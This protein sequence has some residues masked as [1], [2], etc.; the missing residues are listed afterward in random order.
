MMLTFVSCTSNLWERVFDFPTYIH[1]SPK[2][3]F[4][5]RSPAKQESWD[6]T[7]LQCWDLKLTWQCCRWSFVWW[8]W[9][10]SHEL[11]V[12][13]MPCSVSIF[14]TAQASSSHRWKECQVYQFVPNTNIPR[15]SESMH[16]IILQLFPVSW[17]SDHPCKEL[18]LCTTAQS[19][20]WPAGNVFPRTFFDLPYPYD[21][22]TVF[23]REFSHPVNFLLLPQK[24][25]I[26]TFFW[27]L[28][29]NFRSACIHVECIPNTRGQ[30]MVLV[31]QVRLISS[32]SSSWDSNSTFFQKISYHPRIPTGTIFVFD[33][34]K[35]TLFPI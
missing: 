1:I 28:R 20:C 11:N 32:I 19:F 30:K 21:H 24:F 3:D 23:A 35:D 8:I 13:H 14:V 27:I 31:V 18:R 17:N 22:A 29:W 12:C 33:E 5:S 10:K 7:N 26:R 6:R 4:Y 16:W 9:K 34:R 25:A 15:Q 2:V